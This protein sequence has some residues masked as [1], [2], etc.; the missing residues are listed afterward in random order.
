M[1]EKVTSILFLAIVALVLVGFAVSITILLVKR[2]GRGG[3]F[4]SA[5]AKYGWTYSGNSQRAISDV[6][7]ILTPTIYELQPGKH[8]VNYVTT[9]RSGGVDFR[10]LRYHHQTETALAGRGRGGTYTLLILGPGALRGDKSGAPRIVDMRIVEMR[11][12][13][14]IEFWFTH[15]LKGKLAAF[16]E[17]FAGARVAVTRVAVTRVA[18][19][20]LAVPDDPAWEWSLFSSLEAFDKMDLH[21]AAGHALEELTEPGDAVFVHQNSIILGR[22]GE[23]RASMAEAVP[24]IIA[25]L[26]RV[27]TR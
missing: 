7:A 10:L 14:P 13:D 6:E 20:D 19:S 18:G 22:Q 11:S 27:L 26:M 3:A 21:G 15:R 17:G 12:G 25:T 24:R 1:S 8:E 9:G 4:R 2:L 23:L 16:A 5:A